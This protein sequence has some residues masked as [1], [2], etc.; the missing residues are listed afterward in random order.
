MKGFEKLSQEVIEQD[1]CT[2]C[3]TCIGVCPTSTLSWK[4]EKVQ[5][6]KNKCIECGKC[7]VACPGKKFSML[8]FSKELYKTEYAKDSLFGNYETIWNAYSGDETIRQ[9]GASGGVVTQ[10][11]VDMLSRKMID[12]AVVVMNKRDNACEFEAIVATNRQ[13]IIMAAKSKYV[14]IP[15]NEI[16]HRI[17][18]CDQKSIAFVGLP[19]QIQ[20]MRKAMQ[21]DKALSEKL[22]ILISLFCGFNMEKEAT[23]YLIKKSG[24]EK[25][26]IRYLSYRYKKNSMTG[27][28]IKGEDGTD[29]FVNKHGYTFLN[30]MFSPKRC[31]KC[32]DYSGEFADISVGDA[33]DKCGGWSRV[34]IRTECGRKV[35]EKSCIEKTII[36]EK[37]NEQKI[38]VS[39]KMVVSYKKRQISVREKIMKTFPEYDVEYNKIDW[40]T[41][42]KGVALYMILAFFK[43]RFGK[44]MEIIIPFKALSKLSERLK[45]KEVD[46][47]LDGIKKQGIINAETVRYVFWGVIT[48][49]VN[50]GSYILLKFIT[51]YKIANLFSIIF[52]KIF[53]YCTNRKFVFQTKTKGR[54]QLYEIIRYAIVRVAT[55]IVDFV[56]L[57]MLTDFCKID[58]RFGKMIMIA[59]ST[60]LNYFLGKFFVFTKNKEKGV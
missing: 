7:V 49:G 27:F 30:L 36:A 39:Q 56:G 29:F 1:L 28:Y 13:E 10:L 37:C 41:K 24:I 35:F 16:I 43:T 19:C 25:E 59:V 44:V 18:E 15:V 46:N 54:K 20:G 42:L 38:K 50:Y 51:D 34:F 6:D 12:G 47:S 57:I 52:T 4:N 53:A 23:D 22:A 26:K 40:Q 48:V 31:W 33:W 32:Y 45:G 21:N 11:L 17:K 60:I 8:Q 2:G 55:G 14:V 3:G 5:N 58:D 9:V